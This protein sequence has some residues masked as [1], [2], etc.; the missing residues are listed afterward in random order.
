MLLPVQIPYN[1][2]SIVERMV[3]FY[4]LCFTH[5]VGVVVGFD[6]D[7]YSGME[8]RSVSIIILVQGQSEIPFSVQFSTEDGT[9]RGKSNMVNLWYSRPSYIQTDPCKIFV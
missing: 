4:G 5:F 6:P 8:G 1:N 2:V 3:S 7:S 9:A